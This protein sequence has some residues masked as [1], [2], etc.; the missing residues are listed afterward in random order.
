MDTTPRSRFLPSEKSFDC[1][2][3]DPRFWSKESNLAPDRSGNRKRK[4]SEKIFFR[5]I[6]EII[7]KEEASFALGLTQRG[8]QGPKPKALFLRPLWA[9]QAAL[10]GVEIVTRVSAIRPARRS[11]CRFSVLAK[12]CF[13]NGKFRDR[14]EERVAADHDLGR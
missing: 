5:E 13:D 11:R 10:S 1:A 6:F 12:S 8:Q 4:L 14:P 7:S 3:F 2:F 9:M